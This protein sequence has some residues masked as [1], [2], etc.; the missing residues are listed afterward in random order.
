MHCAY[1]LALRFGVDPV[2]KLGQCFINAP[3]EGNAVCNRGRCG[4]RA[5]TGDDLVVDLTFDAVGL[6]QAALQFR[7]QSGE[8]GRAWP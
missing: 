8:S 4:N 3:P 1:D 6:D 7:R 2:R 5:E